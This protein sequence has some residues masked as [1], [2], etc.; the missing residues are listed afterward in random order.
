[1][2]RGRIAA[3]Q[4]FM[5]EERRIVDLMVATIPNNLH[6]SSARSNA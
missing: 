6:H 4:W 1:M 5:A 3:A 2:V